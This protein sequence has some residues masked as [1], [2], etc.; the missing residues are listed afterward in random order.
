MRRWIELAKQGDQAAWDNLVRH[1]RGMAYTVAYSKLRD[2]HLA[3]D[4]AQEAFAETLFR[5]G[6][7]FFPSMDLNKIAGVR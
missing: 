6:S 3:E 2:S 7:P 5:S 1:F 4:A